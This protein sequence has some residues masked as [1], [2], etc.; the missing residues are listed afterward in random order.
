MTSDVLMRPGRAL[1][2]IGLLAPCLVAS[3]EQRAIEELVVEGESLEESE[4]RCRI[5]SDVGRARRGF[6][7]YYEQSLMMSPDTGHDGA[8]CQGRG[9]DW[10]D[11][12][13]REA[14]LDW[15]E[16]VNQGR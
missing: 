10:F 16:Q 15:Q 8:D 5:T 12:M 3:A 13:L 1:F 9:E 7:T 11:K 14:N 4:E 6:S 2:C